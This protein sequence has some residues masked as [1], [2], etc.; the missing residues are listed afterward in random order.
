MGQRM[1]KMQCRKLVLIEEVPHNYPYSPI[2]PK[3]R[4]DL[5]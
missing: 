3:V 2:S 4:K 1:Q 5:V